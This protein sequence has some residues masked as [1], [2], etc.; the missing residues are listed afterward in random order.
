M[1]PGRLRGGAEIRKLALSGRSGDSPMR[2][3]ADSA[4]VTLGQT[5]FQLANAQLAIGP[6]ASPVRL[7][8][9]S[10]TGR[11][12]GQGLGGEVKGAGGRIG[13]VPLIVEGADG[14]WAFIGGALTF[15]AGMTVHDAQASARFQPLAVPDFSLTLKDGR[16]AAT[17][18][19]RTPAAGAMVAKVDIAHDLG[20][21]R[22]RA[23]LAVPGLMFGPALQPEQV[24][25][26]TRGVVANVKGTVTGVGHIVWSGSTVNS[27]GT[28]RTD[29]MSLA[30]AF[31][32]VE[33]LSTEIH[34]TD[35]LGMVSAPGQEVRIRLV[36]PGVE[37]RDGV[38]RLQLQAGQKVHVEGGGWPFSGGQLVLLPTTMDFGADV[39]RYLTFRVIGLDA[40]AFI[41]A[42]DLK[43]ISATG[44]F[45]G[46]LPLIFNARGGRVAGG[47]L[48]A[49]QMGK[50]P[51]IMPEGVLPTIPCDPALQS[52]T[53]SYVGAVSN[54]QLG[55]MGKLAFDAL[56][57]L[58]YKC[59]TILM[60]GSLDGEMVTNVVFNGVN[61][62]KIA[63][64]ATGF[65]KGLTGLPFIFNVRIS[66]P[67]RGLLNA[68]QSFVDPS[69]LIQN[70]IG[71][72]VQNKIRAAVQPAESDSMRQGEHK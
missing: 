8:A 47:V 31:G 19:L 37:V 24:T 15:N 1:G 23:D 44:T 69:A 62:G 41:Q 28:F 48:T 65:A 36:N 64:P 70:S 38:V 4:R 18:T 2:L 54:E 66:A 29:N 33:G 35:L 43:D 12:A 6:Q 17:G 9:A 42:M 22:G 30:A 25:L 11:I 5:G 34:F 21:S 32:P 3:S 7:T 57:N 14:R 56:K 40:G 72:Q 39:D 45:D 71:D 51:L 20:T 59:L 58:Q 16:I 61:R 26:L 55:A 46:I 10:L 50:P 67:F 27:T 60:D 52:G 63:G 49:R 68:A 13:A 53:L